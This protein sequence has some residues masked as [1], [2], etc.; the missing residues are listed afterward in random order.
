MYGCDMIRKSNLTSTCHTDKI[1]HK[2]CHGWELGMDIQCKLQ[3]YLQKQSLRKTPDSPCFGGEWLPHIQPGSV[4]WLVQ[5]CLCSVFE[6]H[7]CSPTWASLFTVFS[8]TGKHNDQAEKHSHPWG[9]SWNLV[10][11]SLIFHLIVHT[12][13][14][15][16]ASHQM[17][18]KGA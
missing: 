10:C 1:H 14:P 12:A 15:S 11:Y 9:L 13:W 16:L 18:S 4:V 7:T 17:C 2:F 5:L 8:L 3:T 6:D